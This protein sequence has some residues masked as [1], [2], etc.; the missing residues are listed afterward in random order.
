MTRGRV[1]CP[2]CG[3]DVGLVPEPFR[4]GTVRGWRV[5]RHR[6]AGTV[7]LCVGSFSVAP[8]EEQA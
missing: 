7:A 4:A 6:R 1:T 3:R 8:A 5:S 2:E